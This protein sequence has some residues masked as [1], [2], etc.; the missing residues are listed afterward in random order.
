MAKFIQGNLKTN[1]NQ[2]VILGS[3]DDSTLYWDGTEL[4]LTTTISGIT[5]TISGHLATK[6][7]VDDNAGG[8][9]A[10]VEDTTPQLGGDLDVNAKNIELTPTGGGSDDTACGV[11]VTQTVDTNSVGIG[12]ALFMAADGNFDEADADAS[13]TVP[14]TALALEAG[15]G[16]K[17][18]LLMGYMRHDAWDWTPGGLLFVSDTVGTLTQTAPSSTGQQIQIVGKATTADVIY[19]NPS[20]VIGEVE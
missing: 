18:V 1:D 17:K 19:F 15:T 16:S 6:G 13:T 11:I 9:T 7:Y 4:I 20:L 5:P 14:C 8:M 12:S 10:I 3:D 2:K